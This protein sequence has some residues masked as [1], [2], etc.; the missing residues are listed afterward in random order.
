MR[1]TRPSGSEG[2]AAQTNGPSLPYRRQL[3][4]AIDEYDRHGGCGGNC[5][6]CGG[7]CARRRP[8][9]FVG[10]AVR[11]IFARYVK[12]SRAGR[13]AVRPPIRCAVRAF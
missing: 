3:N 13:L 6:Q 11:T 4:E 1:E 8:P 10:S 9:A 12:R 2:G 5:S 7:R